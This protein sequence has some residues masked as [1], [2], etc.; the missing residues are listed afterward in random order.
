MLGLDYLSQYETKQHLI[1]EQLLRN[2][3]AAAHGEAYLEYDNEG[4]AE[5]YKALMGDGKEQTLGLL[6]LLRD[7]IV[8]ASYME[9]FKNH[10]IILV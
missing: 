3:H 2:R 9:R 10:P 4:F 6:E 5:V 7:Q 8:T 1:D